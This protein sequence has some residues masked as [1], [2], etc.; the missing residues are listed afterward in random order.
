MIWQFALGVLLVVNVCS[1]TISKVATDMLPK[2]KSIGIFWQ[3]LFCAIIAVVYALISGIT[4]LG[5][6]LLLVAAVGFFNAFGNYCQWHAFGLSFSRSSLFFP[7]M[8]VWTISLALIFLEETLLWNIQL[9][10]GAALCFAAMW[11]FRIS[12]KNE[13]EKKEAK[14][15]PAK[16]WFVYTVG[17]I[18]IFGT[19]AFLLKLFSFTIPRETFLMSFYSGALLGSLPILYLEKQNPFRAHVSSKTFLTIIAV[20]ILAMGATLALYWT[21]QLGGP[22]SLVQPV[23]GTFIALSPV[24]L[25]WFA[26]KER[27]G[28]TKTEWFAFFLGITGAILVL[29]R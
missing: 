24:L 21:Y 20:A 29:L 10:L 25:G 13:S 5:L 15:I 23:R 14:S 8:E 2:N 19:A 11:L 26:F 4:A 12:G 28:L 1:L 16:R 7:L 22:I 9:V 27:K 17:M 3:Y 6:P 18:T